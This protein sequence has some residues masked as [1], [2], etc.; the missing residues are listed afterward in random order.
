VS[1]SPQS[2]SGDPGASSFVA[3]NR[4]PTTGAN[5][6]TSGIDSAANRAR[7]GNHDHSRLAI[8]RPVKRDICIADNFHVSNPKVAE[9]FTNAFAQLRA[10]STR[11]ADLRC[12]DIFAADLGG[13]ASFIDG[14]AHSRGS[15]GDSHTQGI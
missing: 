11:Q 12:Q 6:F 2:P 3:C 5:P 14:F 9:R 15:S 8:R 4:T 1:N 7:P 13:F 10:A